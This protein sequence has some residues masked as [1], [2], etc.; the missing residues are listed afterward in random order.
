MAGSTT[1]RSHGERRRRSGW[2]AVI[3]VVAVVTGMVFPSTARAAN[4]VVV[5][6]ARSGSVCAVSEC[7]APVGTATVAPDSP[8][9]Y[10]LVASDGGIFAFDAPFY[11][12]T[13]GTGLNKPIVGMASTPD[14]GGYY[15]VASDGGIFSFGDAAFHGSTGNL[16]LN[17]PIVGMATLPPQPPAGQTGPP[18]TT[19]ATV[20]G[21]SASS[22]PVAGGQTLVITGTGLSGATSV[23]FGPYPAASVTSISATTLTVTTPT[24]YPST[25]DVQVTTPQGTSPTTPADQYTFESPAPADSSTYTPTAGTVT[26]SNS[27][28]LTVT[29]GGLD[30]AGSDVTPQPWLVSLAEG[31]TAP[32]VGDNY[33]L[34]PGTTAEPSGLAGTVTAVTVNADTTTLTVAPAPLDQVMSQVSVDYSG[35]INGTDAQT[36]AAVTGGSVRAADTSPPS[37]VTFPTADASALDCDGSGGISGSVGLSLEDVETNVVLDLGSLISKPFVEVE[38][39]YQTVVSFNLTATASLDCKLSAEWVNEHTKLILLGDS[40]ATLAFAPDLTFKLSAA[41]TITVSQHSY[42]TTGFTTDSD[43]TIQKLDGKSADPAVVK[44]SGALSAEVFAGVD[45]QVGLLNVIGVGMSIGV[46]GSATAQVD[47]TPPQVCFSFAAYVKASLY[48]YLNLWVK[49]WKYQPFAT[50]LDLADIN[51]CE[52][53]NQT[54]PPN[55]GSPVITSINFPNGTVGQPYQA[56]LTTADNRAGTWTISSG[57]LP[58][59]LALSGNAISGT[60]TTP[61]TFTFDIT[62]TDTNGLSTT[63]PGTI[64]IGTSTGASGSGSGNGPTGAI[65][66]TGGA[67]G[68]GNYCAVLSVGNID[69][70]G[71]GAYHGE[72]GDGGTTSSDIPVQVVGITNATNVTSGYIGYC[73]LLATGGIDCW[74]V[75]NQGDLGDGTTL[76]SDV[77]VPVA[78]V[79]NAV[80][81]KS[82]A[83]SYCALLS[84]GSIDCWGP[85]NNGE[86][87]DNTTSNSAVPV[88]V[89][90][91]TDA[92]SITSD[93]DE[94]YCALLSTGRI[95]CWGYNGNG[96][97]GDG[98]TTDSEVPV[99]VTGIINATSVSSDNN[100]S[101]CAILATGDVDCWGTS[102]YGLGDGSTTISDVPV[103]VTGISNAT[104]LGSDT[105]GYCAVLFTGGVDCWGY[106][107]NGELGD[108][109][110]IDSEVPVPVTG[111]TNAAKLNLNVNSDYDGYCAVLTTGAVDCWGNN[112]YG[113]LGN[114]TSASYSDVPVP[115]TGIANAVSVVSEEGSGGVGLSVCAV[116]SN[117]SVD[118]WGYNGDGEL[119][120]GTT[121]GSDV[122]VPVTGIGN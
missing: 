101:Y 113:E 64:T 102:N 34:P 12:S 44:A 119:G 2:W 37:T 23:S 41:G 40:G 25:V 110:T 46:G 17:K 63:G 29:G 73:A 67:A 53:L 96:E 5:P 84:T 72:L 100:E 66:V 60:P 8:S 115:V 111:I 81:I 21:L 93:N 68:I 22:G 69:C 42:H 43:G 80:S 13:G 52:P 47:S 121:V 57:A 1:S 92:V 99:P 11:G 71:D 38:V 118:C 55:L 39:S 61:G 104:S 89:S 50:E 85:N 10:E 56:Q 6:P 70:W 122:P 3:A 59:G 54:P 94:G 109:T 116:L 27:D 62:F 35:P 95:Y 106:N 120:N 26:N 112:G 16:A 74:G 15:L 36:D 20:T 4:E 45:I 77:P 33:Y 65:S 24:G 78:G 105:A 103:P 88:L 114:G 49:E 79:T 97:L 76:D 9:G 117:G 87:G 32:A 51:G 7:P 19:A 86:L 90:G 82:D 98:T 58:D 31:A 107:G 75:N 28:V 30:G 108:G 18:A 83:G 14:G 91:I 48:A